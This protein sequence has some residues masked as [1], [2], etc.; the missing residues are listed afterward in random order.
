[1]RR[2]RASS[3]QRRARAAPRRRWRRRAATRPRPRRAWACRP[4]PP[5]DRSYAARWPARRS[6]S[7][8]APEALVVAADLVSVLRGNW[9]T[10]NGNQRFG[11]LAA[12]QFLG[13]LVAE[14]GEGLA[15]AFLDDVPVGS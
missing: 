9:L 2:T 10:V 5:E 1:M 8:P 4:T 6:R 14:L 3:R 12:Q 13:D 7:F 15:D 11:G